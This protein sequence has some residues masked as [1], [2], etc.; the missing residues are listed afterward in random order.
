MTQY[1]CGFEGRL[2]AVR[3]GGRLNG[4]EFLEVDPDGSTLRV[5]LILPSTGL[6]P[7]NV[8]IDGGERIPIVAVKAVHSGPGNVLVV[9]TRGPSDFSYYTLHLVG[10]AGFDQ[11]LREVSFSFKVDCDT[12]FD[13]A[14]SATASP[15]PGSGPEI[16][17]LAKDY[18]A[19]RR[20]LLDRMSVLAPQWTERNPADAGVALAE[21]IAYGAD[22]LSYRQ[23]AI[24]TEA[25]LGT[26]RRRI[27]VR[28]HA[29][30]VGYRMH[31]GCSARALLRFTVN[32]TSLEL[33]AATAVTTGS[34]VFETMEPVMLH[35]GQNELGLYT[36]SDR[37][38]L[39]PL[40][41]TR[42]TIDGHASLAPGGLLMLVD[43]DHRWPVRLT[44]VTE[45]V[46][47]LT[48]QPV[49]EVDWDPADALPFAMRADRAWGNLVLAD[50][51]QSYM[52]IDV[53]GSRLPQAPLSRTVAADPH[54]PASALL[55]MDPRHAAPVITLIP[56]ADPGEVWHA[57]PDLLSSDGDDPNFVVE[58]DDDAVAWL[59]FGDGV[60]GRRSAGRYRATYRIGSGPE[61]NVGAETLTR[62]SIPD[63]RIAA[64]TNPIPAAGGCAPESVEQV[65]RDAPQ[66]YQVQERAVTPADYAEVSARL[67]GVQRAAAT[68]RW[69]G[70]WHTVFVAA[71]RAGGAPVDPGF[72][73]RLRT[74]LERYRMAGYDLDVAEPHHVPLRVEL[75]ICVGAEH[76]R[77]DVRNEVQR[78][79]ARLFEPDRLTF[80]QP[81]YLSAIY[82]AAQGVPGVTSVLVVA[83]GRRDGRDGG[84]GLADGVLSMGPGEIAR[85]DN[86]RNFPERGVVRVTAGG[87]R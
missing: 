19:F 7:D 68:F 31:D 53:P 57:V 40:G 87:G 85:L 41:A 65:R 28:R 2:D 61:G 69:T 25:Y 3:A 66:A 63:S 55:A 23:D 16:D 76:S 70:S 11:R 45:S 59:R 56:Q 18:G 49:T 60:H 27:S 17:Y 42:A 75:Q 36:W 4:I 30:L 83:F 51:G 86:D 13:C 6:T 64:V 81:V 58:I 43:T 33:A 20:L 8:R 73:A 50:N 15:E 29:R 32:V 62:L 54:E 12:D 78:A 38:C 71:D 74:H 67:A 80:G 47:E 77:S 37:D 82:A 35:K 1:T 10:V 44:A 72:T 22:R 39:L 9:Q 5:Q 21:L 48:N 24:A 84:R 14:A 46:D 34:V 52:D 79:V 26:A